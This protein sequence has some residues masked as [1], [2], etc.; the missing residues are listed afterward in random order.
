MAIFLIFAV[1]S[2]SA[3]KK[4]HFICTLRD[5]PWKTV[6]QCRKT[7]TSDLVEKDSDIIDSPSSVEEEIGHDNDVIKRTHC[8]KNTRESDRTSVLLDLLCE[9][10]NLT[11]KEIT[12]KECYFRKRIEKSKG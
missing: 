12:R 10:K 1:L 5:C 4:K 3:I 6:I 11:T 7:L 9:K 8:N 2:N